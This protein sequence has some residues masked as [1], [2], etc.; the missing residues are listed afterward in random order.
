MCELQIR[1]K[2]E[3]IPNSLGS[4]RDNSHFWAT[5]MPAILKKLLWVAWSDFC[6]VLENCIKE[7]VSFEISETNFYAYRGLRFV[8]DEELPNLCNFG[9]KK[10]Y[11][12]PNWALKA[13][14]QYFSLY[15]W[16]FT[17]WKLQIKTLE[18]SFFCFCKRRIS[19]FEEIRRWVDSSSRLQSFVLQL[20]CVK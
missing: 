14:F 16:I 4:Q 20:S 3:K 18:L 13:P 5:E 8:M 6:Y 19:R 15:R 11:H 7:T 10:T 9:A 12:H 17:L 2:Q 1:I